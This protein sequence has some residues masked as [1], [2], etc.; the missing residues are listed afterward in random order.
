MKKVLVVLYGSIEFD[1]R[2]KRVLGI[3]KEFGAVTLVDVASDSGRGQL[4]GVDRN[5]IF[6]KR[7]WGQTQR[8]AR[9]AIHAIIAARRLRPQL[10]FAEDYY[11]PLL[12]R[13]IK[14]LTGAKLIYDAHELIVP[15]VQN[16][17]QSARDRFWYFCERSAIYDSDLVIAAN[18]ERARLMK[19]HYGFSGPVTYMRNIPK[20]VT[21]TS[22]QL[23]DALKCYPALAKKSDDEK[24]VLYQGDISIK[25]GLD[26]FV[27]CLEYLPS[28]VRLVLVGQGPDFEAVQSLGG[29]FR[30]SGRFSALGRIGQD[31][32]PAVTQFA[33]VGIVTY[34]RQGM[35]NLFC[36]PN[37]IF[38]YVNAGVR[39]VATDQAPLKEIVERFSIGV[40]IESNDTPGDVAQKIL[41]CLS[42]PID[43]KVARS[44]IN[45]EFNSEAEDGRVRKEVGAI[46]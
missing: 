46:C 10:V 39:I 30:T 18:P 7:S 25:R 4:Q 41:R 43:M 8:Y 45:S 23:A 13:I 31:L 22:E 24:I 38:E 27:R 3:A 14:A 11:T 28:N 12:G 32:L 1:G 33:D 26:L 9:F 44:I 15:E 16:A 35:N 42:M 20:S 2:V 19:D 6:L 36:A 17:K 21:P 5:P 37:K 40:L 29:A 34:P